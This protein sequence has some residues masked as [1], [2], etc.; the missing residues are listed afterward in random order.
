MTPQNCETCPEHDGLAR[1]HSFLWGVF[2]ASGV[3]VGIVVTVLMMSVSDSRALVEGVQADNKAMQD[4][5]SDLKLEML[6]ELKRLEIRIIEEL[7]EQK[8]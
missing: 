4:D 6:K 7:R 5:I 8:K 2:I 3:L 1:K